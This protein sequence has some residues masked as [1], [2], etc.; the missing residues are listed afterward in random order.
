MAT[1]VP[2]DEFIKAN[3]GALAK[4]FAASLSSNPKSTEFI[5]PGSNM[6]AL[7]EHWAD[8]S[9]RSEESNVKAPLVLLA[10]AIAE[11][12]DS[13]I[14]VEKHPASG[15]QK[16]VF[17]SANN[18]YVTVVQSGDKLL[19]SGIGSVLG[20]H[21]TEQFEKQISLTASN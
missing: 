9:S 15:E 18:F 17:D 7:I 14:T 10:E 13:S 11:K 16:V 4:G 5:A 20:Q 12:G 8:D 1:E 6:E 2:S 21:I 19:I 3:Y